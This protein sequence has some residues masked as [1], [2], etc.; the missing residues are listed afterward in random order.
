MNLDFHSERPL[1]L[2]IAEQ[3]EDGILSGAYAEEAQIPSTTE[4]SMAYKINPATVLKGFTRLV[5]DG[6]LYKRR[7]VGMFV[8][9]GAVLRVREKRKET[10]FNDHVATFTK[11]ARRLGLSLAETVAQIERS[12]TEN[13][14]D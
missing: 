5:D 7:G 10:F 1:F 9:P 8:S 6:I 11:E 3:I 12:F 2:Q 13:E 14:S 4:I